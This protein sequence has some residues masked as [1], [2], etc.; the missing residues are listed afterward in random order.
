MRNKTKV[1]IVEDELP[2]AMLMVNV[3]TRVGCE[4]EAVC[5]G[6]KAMELATQKRFD[7][8]TIDIHL[9]DADGFQICTQLKERHIS[10]KTPVIFISASPFE[11]NIVEAKKRGAVDY[12]TKP[13]DTTD[14]VYRVIFY[15]NARH[16]Q[17]GNE[18]AETQAIKAKHE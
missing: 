3:L 4:V 11:Q 17:V 16:N 10:R 15:A 13:F 18:I 7:L 1:L 14:L 6:K 9:P 8:I 2:L 12:I 5:T